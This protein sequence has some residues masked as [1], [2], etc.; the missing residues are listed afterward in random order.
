MPNNSFHSV[1]FLIERLAITQFQ[2]GSPQGGIFCCAAGKHFS[3]AV[4]EVLREFF[5]DLGLAR[6][7]EPQALKPRSDFLCP[8][9]HIHGFQISDFGFSGS[10]DVEVHG[11]SKAEIQSRLVHPGR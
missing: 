3:V 5:D 2:E 10:L 1:Q 7:L 4:F 11:Q 8:V 6:R 9:R